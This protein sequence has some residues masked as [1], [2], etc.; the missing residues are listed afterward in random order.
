[1][2]KAIAIPIV[3][4]A[5]AAAEMLS[6]A[7]A[8][9]RRLTKK[10]KDYWDSLS[11]EDRKFLMPFGATKDRLMLDGA[12]VTY[13]PVAGL[14]FGTSIPA[15]ELPVTA[16]QQALPTPAFAQP[17]PRSNVQNEALKR[18]EEVA[19]AIGF[20]AK[21]RALPF[22]SNVIV[23]DLSSQLKRQP[24]PVIHE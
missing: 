1:M 9:A 21:Q 15:F 5:A 17:M 23:L 22:G 14:D 11:A 10:G 18:I 16:N 8:G 4:L 3:G 2:S 6:A 24:T 7:G 19:S 13:R 12:A 20:D